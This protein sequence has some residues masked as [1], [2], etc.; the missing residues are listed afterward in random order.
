MEVSWTEKGFGVIEASQAR[1][2]LAVGMSQPIVSD[3][4]RLVRQI[5]HCQT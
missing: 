2:V 4:I 1:Y 5:E 3:V